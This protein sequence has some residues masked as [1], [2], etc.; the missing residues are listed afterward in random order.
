MAILSGATGTRDKEGTHVEAHEVG[1]TIAE[2][3]HEEHR[4]PAAPRPFSADAFRRRT[5][6]FLGVI[7]ML[8]AIASLGGEYNMKETINFNILASDTWAFYQARNIRQT[9]YQI[10]AD[11]LAETLASAADLSPEA[12]QALEKRLADY[13]ERIAH[14]E[15]EPKDNSGKKEL[16]AKATQYAGK[17]DVAQVRD[18]NF[19]YARALYAIAIILGSVSIVALS[20]L[21][22]YLTAIFAVIATILSLNGFYLFFELPFHAVG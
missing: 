22:L 17:R 14:F 12:R 21:L 9:G 20:R 15:S 3:G 2:S 4:A 7:G 6:V 8:L 13:R 5:A 11:G 10:A 1:E 18:T 16:L 19:D